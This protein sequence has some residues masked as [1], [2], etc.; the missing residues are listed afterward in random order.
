M[1]EYVV[2]VLADRVVNSA[3][4]MKSNQTKTIKE[5]QRNQNHYLISGMYNVPD[6]QNRPNKCYP[7]THTNR[8]MNIPQMEF[9]REAIIQR[10][11][12]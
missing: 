10:E 4:K 2:V 5:H 12:Y 3:Y 8:R 1:K 6:Q 11:G 9:H 7:T